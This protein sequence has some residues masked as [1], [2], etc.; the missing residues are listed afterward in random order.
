MRPVRN[1]RAYPNRWCRRPSASETTEITACPTTHPWGAHRR[2]LRGSG[3][4]LS[5]P[6]PRCCGL[7]RHRSFLQVEAVRAAT[8]I[9]RTCFRDPTSTQVVA[10]LC[11][12]KARSVVDPP[13]FGWWAGKWEVSMADPDG[14]HVPVVPG[15]AERVRLWLVAL[16]P[17]ARPAVDVLSALLGWK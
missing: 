11:M 4:A 6:F 8:P 15:R 17:L 12:F 2:E 3:T 9:D 13:S 16:G 1:E 10:R 14:D 5:A 7:P